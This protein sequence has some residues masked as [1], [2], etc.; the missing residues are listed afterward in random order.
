M[1]E[2]FQRYKSI[3]GVSGHALNAAEM[4]LI[5][6]YTLRTL[7]QE[8]V[9]AFKV[10]MC[11][12]EIDRDFEAF[13]I[14]TLRKL[15]ELFTGKTVIA[16]HNA[17]VNNQCARIYAA[18]AMEVPNKKTSYGDQ[19]MRLEARCYLPRDGNE[20]LINL[21]ETGMRKEVSVGCA[22]YKVTCSIC[23]NPYISSECTH[24]AGNN[25]C[26]KKLEDAKDAYELSFVAVPAQPAAGVVK[27]GD[28]KTESPFHAEL[29][30]LIDL[31][32]NIGESVQRLEKGKDLRIISELPAE[33]KEMDIN[34]VAQA[35]AS[36][37]Q[38]SLHPPLSQQTSIQGVILDPKVEE[39]IR[40][41]K[42]L[43]KKSEGD[44]I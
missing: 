2:A 14:P 8:D 36:E 39:L 41:A 12:N 32:K 21:I 37:L 20:R 4:D 24:H 38:K 22:V 34:L 33:I 13:T 17:N 30:A 25:G 16:D 26:Y 19:Y 27:G 40:S 42:A 18:D 15:G 23:G 9:F 6:K 10:T 35:L 29:N 3:S 31:V 11:D 28:I 1:A 43:I 44:S 5:N 7:S